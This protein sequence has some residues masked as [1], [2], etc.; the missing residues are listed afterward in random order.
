MPFVEGSG[1][2]IL[3]VDDQGI[4]ADRSPGF[5]AAL[6]SQAQQQPPDSLTMPALIARQTPHSETGD[7][8]GMKRFGVGRLQQCE[9]YLSRRK[10]VEA[11]D[12][13]RGIGGNEHE[14]L[15]HAATHV[16]VRLLMKEAIEGW[17]ATREGLAVVACG[18]EQLLLKQGGRGC[19]LAPSPP[20]ARHWPQTVGRWRHERP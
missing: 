2:R 11:R 13:I 5:Q 8:E 20:A 14:G 3:G 19:A 15:A 10:G 6:H 17:D 16:L 9:L 7:W 18:V 12:P 1:L 4:A